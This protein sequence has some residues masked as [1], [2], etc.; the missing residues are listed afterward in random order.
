M[1]LTLSGVEKAQDFPI[2]RLQVVAPRGE[3]NS[4]DTV[5]RSPIFDC[6]RRPFAA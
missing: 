5:D 6:R 1:H 4:L 2:L 3:T